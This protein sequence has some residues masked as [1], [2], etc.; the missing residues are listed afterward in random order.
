MSM[1]DLS[2]KLDSP[3]INTSSYKVVKS[4]ETAKGNPKPVKPEASKKLPDLTQNGYQVAQ[5]VN[6]RKA[7]VDTLGSYLVLG[8]LIGNDAT[9]VGVADD[10]AIPPAV[11]N[12][13]IKT[14]PLAI[15]LISYIIKN[16]NSSFISPPSLWGERP[17]TSIKDQIETFPA[18][19]NGPIWHITTGEKNGP[20][21]HVTLAENPG[22]TIISTPLP[23]E[24]GPTILITPPVDT[25]IQKLFN[26]PMRLSV[27]KLIE[28]LKENGGEDIGY[29]HGHPAYK[30]DG[31]TVQLPGH[32]HNADL[33]KTSWNEWFKRAR[34]GT[35]VLQQPNGDYA[36]RLP[37]AR[38]IPIPK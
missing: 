16:K 27:R 2:I 26:E 29:R 4:R 36:F 28:A 34:D 22:P 32:G 21:R 15:A 12:A 37:S 10:W 14:G 23:Q 17:G 24:A 19:P 7:A 30:I 25:T 31:K 18:Q 3:T 33:S 8:Y 13:I 9:G 1:N 35:K 20:T 6:V 38:E 5:E 11:V